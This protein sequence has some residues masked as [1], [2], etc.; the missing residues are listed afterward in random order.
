[1]RVVVVGL[2]IQGKKRLRVAGA[3]VVATVDPVAS[4]NFVRLE[5]VPLDQY[6]AA[7]L[8]IPDAP[9]MALI[10]YLTAAGKHFLVEKPLFSESDE[11]LA[12]LAGEAA[13]RGVVGYTAYNHRFEPHIARLKEVIASNSLGRIYR[14]RLFYGNGTARDVRDSLWRDQHAGVLQD[15][16]SHLL[17][18][19]LFWFGVLPERLQVQTARRFENRAFDHIICCSDGAMLVEMEMSLLSWRNHFVAEIYGERG[20]VHI[21]SLCKWGPST[22]TLYERLLPS[23]RPPSHAVTLVQPDPTWELEYAHFKAL[24]QGGGGGNLTNDYE[25]N[26]TLNHLSRE[27]LTR[28]PA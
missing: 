22:F 25:I 5:E 9:K 13:R 23:G 6:D 3:D 27:A 2:G 15:L 19:L 21:E 1:M 10:Q 16:G 8:C 28:F 12:V 18:L 24:C 7:L 11:A 14:T 4:A 26:R 20:S 17:D